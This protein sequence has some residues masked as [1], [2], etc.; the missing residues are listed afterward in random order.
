MMNFAG[1]GEQLE[2][3][4]AAAEEVSKNDKL[5]IENELF[6]ENYE[7]YIENEGILH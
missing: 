3:L 6:I 5:F 2:Q 4:R 1:L 7:C